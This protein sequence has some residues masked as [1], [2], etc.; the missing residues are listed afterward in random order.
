MDITATSNDK[1]GHALPWDRMWECWGECI[2]L[3]Q[4]AL[5]QPLCPTMS[6]KCLLFFFPY[7]NT[8]HHRAH[9]KTLCKTPSGWFTALS[10]KAFSSRELVPVPR[11]Q[12]IRL[13]VLLEPFKS[14]DIPLVFY[15]SMKFFSAWCRRW[16]I[17]INVIVSCWQKIV[18]TCRQLGFWANKHVSSC[19]IPW[20]L[21]IKCRFW[22]WN[23]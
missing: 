4:K 2:T 1:S 6:Y 10:C 22:W 8:S 11:L 3:R 9:F 16:T 13:P 20:R 15:R 21:W 5:C 14:K 19:W 7:K 23:T 12:H 18:F 17:V